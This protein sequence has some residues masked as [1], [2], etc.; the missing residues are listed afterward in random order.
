M[1]AVYTLLIQSNG[2]GPLTRLGFRFLHDAIGPAHYLICVYKM[3]GLRRTAFPSE[4]TNADCES[5]MLLPLLPGPQQL[6]PIPYW[7]HT[8]VGT[9]RRLRIYED[10]MPD[11]RKFSVKHYWVSRILASGLQW[12]VVWW[13]CTHASDK[14]VASIAGVETKT[15]KRVTCSMK[16]S[17]HSV[18][19]KWVKFQFI[20]CVLLIPHEF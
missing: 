1:S 9:S 2:F 17:V 6:L 20:I 15:N 19:N 11:F 5:F 18:S 10:S 12:H 14:Y 4:I 8:L 7:I 3:R 13:K 16:R